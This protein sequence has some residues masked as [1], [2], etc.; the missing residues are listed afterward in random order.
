MCSRCPGSAPATAV[1]GQR[2]LQS[3]AIPLP[4]GQGV[5]TALPTPQPLPTV[6]VVARPFPWGAIV[7]A[8][9]VALLV[10]GRK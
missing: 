10:T 4:T 3:F 5:Y 8:V 2:A 6:A 1:A 9:V 7:A